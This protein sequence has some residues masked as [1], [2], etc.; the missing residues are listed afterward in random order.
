M[1]SEVVKLIPPGNKIN[2]VTFHP[3]KEYLKLENTYIVLA[4]KAQSRKSHSSFPH[5]DYITLIF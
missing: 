1:F 2:P 3:N 4:G 5:V